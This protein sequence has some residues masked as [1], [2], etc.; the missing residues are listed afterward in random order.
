V[1]ARLLCSVAAALLAVTASAA[2]V[3]VTGGLIDGKTLPDGSTVYLGIP[4]AAPP[5][6]ALRWEPPQPVVSWQGVREA[7]A[8]PV[9]CAQLS[10]GWNSADAARSG[11]DC[12]YLSIHAPRHEP[13]ARLPVLVWIHG[14]SNRAGSGYGV[15][16]DSPMYR[17]GIV[18]VGVEYRLGIFGFLSLSGLTAR[19]PHHSSGEYGLL[20]QIAAL[21]WVQR[22]IAS[23]G[24]DP[25]N[26]TIG[27][28]SAGAI[29]VGQLLVSPLARGLF[30]RAIQESGSPG[31]PRTVGENEAIG[32]QLFSLNHLAPGSRGLAALRALPVRT[33]LADSVRLRSPDNQF[34]ALW[35][36]STADG[37]VIPRNFDGFY[38]SGVE[39]APVALLIGNVTQEFIVDSPQAAMGLMKTTF[40]TDAARAMPLYGYHGTQPPR[41]DPVLGS[42]GTQV[43]TDLAFRCVSKDEALWA[44]AGGQKVWR[45]QFGVPRPGTHQIS[46]T[47]ELDYVF[48]ER[49][50]GA[51]FGSWPPVQL[52]WANFIKTGDP[53]GH[54][55]PVWPRSGDEGAYMAF[56][57]RGPEE[58]HDRRGP[59]CRLMTASKRRAQGQKPA[60]PLSGPDVCDEARVNPLDA[61]LCKSADSG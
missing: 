27:G 28:Q 37:W 51:T 11:E 40:G 45:Y 34:D 54:G 10:E 35:V 12:L 1:I 23:F 22:N 42:V 32:N 59:I 39:R 8:A 38:G 16:A 15:A 6:G 49:P 55:L 50:A 57:P 7:V 21:R 24:G 36:A 60:E 4:Y 25:H 14:G 30:A 29:D 56:T 9:P 13:G 44:R 33:L 2:Q 26:V 43:I 19:S 17:R 31:I 53:N 5:L 18:V 58:N 52:Y 20:D 47:A 61:L 46:H 3:R 41:A 48:G